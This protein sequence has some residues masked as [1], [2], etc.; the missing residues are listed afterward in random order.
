MRVHARRQRGAVL[1]ALLAVAALGAAFLFVSGRTGAQANAAR[2]QRTVAAIANARE[3]L[4]GFA[5]VHGRLPRPAAS[6]S[7]G[8]EGTLACSSDAACTGV[9]PW[10]ALG[11]EGSDSWGQPLRYSVTPQY[12][13]AP[14][15]RISAVGSKTVLT[16]DSAG[17]F[18]YLAGS[19]TCTLASPCPV[20]V[21]FSS[22][23]DTLGPDEAA[24]AA[25]TMHFMRRPREEGA[26][27][28]LLAWID[29]D[30]LYRLM[31]K[32]GVLP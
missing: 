19:P 12:T 24:N 13:E 28:D 18:S 10:L 17:K 27:D 9:L 32:A 3:A 14:V 20:A 7:D 16:R 30:S 11:I 1:L 6:A 2:E 26:F 22:G 23:R 29:A 15:L 31:D 21:I 5:L 8:R 25:A 4:V